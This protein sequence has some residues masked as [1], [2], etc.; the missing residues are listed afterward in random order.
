MTLTAKPH[1]DHAGD[2]AGSRHQTPRYWFILFKASHTVFKSLRRSCT[3][4]S[5]LLLSFRTSTLCVQG[6]KRTEKGRVIDF[7]NSLI[8]SLAS[9]KL[10]ET[11]QAS[12]KVVMRHSCKHVVFG[13]KAF[14]HALSERACFSSPM[15]DSRPAPYALSCPSCLQRPN[16]MVKKQHSRRMPRSHFFHLLQD[17]GSYAS[18]N[19]CLSQW[20]TYFLCHLHYKCELCTLVVYVF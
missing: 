8:F 6:L 19:K 17:G 1:N 12:W 14:T 11:K 3:T 18:F 2:S 5:I 20:V 7:A 4:L 16:S 15:E 9:S 10:S 13:S